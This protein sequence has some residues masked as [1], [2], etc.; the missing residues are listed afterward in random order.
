MADEDISLV[1]NR[2]S[3]LRDY[4]PTCWEKDRKKCVQR[5][6]WKMCDFFYWIQYSLN[7]N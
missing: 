6:L 5:Q 3:K 7:R 1:V 2:G 4:K